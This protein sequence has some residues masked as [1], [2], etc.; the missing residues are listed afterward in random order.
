[1]KK[2]K[3]CCNGIICN[4]NEAISANKINFLNKYFYHLYNNNYIIITKNCQREIYYIFNSYKH[5][6][7]LHI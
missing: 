3:F 5:L 6:N 7:L 4:T 1:M 2:W